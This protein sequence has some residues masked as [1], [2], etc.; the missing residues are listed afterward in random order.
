MAKNTRDST[1]SRKQ[2]LVLAKLLLRNYGILHEIHVKQLEAYPIACCNISIDGI[3]SVDGE[4]KSVKYELKTTRMFFRKDGK[5]FPRHQKSV[6]GW[7]TVPPSKYEAQCKL[8]ATNLINWTQE[9]LWDDQTKVEVFI[10][11]SKITI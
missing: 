6:L 5:V 10:D 3:A 11:G 9:L 2:T 8:A 7:L 4:E 1:E